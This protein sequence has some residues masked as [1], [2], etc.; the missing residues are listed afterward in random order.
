M[1][2]PLPASETS[3]DTCFCGYYGQ[4]SSAQVVPPCPE[5]G[6]G[7]WDKP[8]PRVTDVPRQSRREMRGPGTAQPNVTRSLKIS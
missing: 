4:A 2:D 3:S 8:F 1:A 5:C 6:N 7:P